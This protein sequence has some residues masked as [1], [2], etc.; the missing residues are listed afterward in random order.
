MLDNWIILLFTCFCSLCQGSRNCFEQRWIS[1][2]S[3]YKLTATAVY[4]WPTPRTHAP[5]LL[6]PGVPL[7]CWVP[8]G[9]LSH[10]LAGLGRCPDLRPI[11][12]S[13]FGPVHSCLV[14]WGTVSSIATANIRNVYQSFWTPG[15]VHASAD[16]SVMQSAVKDWWT[17][18]CSEHVHSRSRLFFFCIKKVI[19]CK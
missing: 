14:G 6:I 13:G 11:I 5:R 1:I 16:D 17:A 4:N 10:P 8:L 12:L 9:G 7:C 3:R 18:P 19:N 2:C 15:F